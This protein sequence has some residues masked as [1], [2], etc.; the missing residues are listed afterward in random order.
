MGRDLRKHAYETVGTIGSVYYKNIYILYLYTSR[1][2]GVLTL[3]MDGRAAFMDGTCCADDD[4]TIIDLEL[5]NF[6][7]WEKVR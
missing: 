2:S 5:E 7:M 1:A 6:A 4:S 3:S